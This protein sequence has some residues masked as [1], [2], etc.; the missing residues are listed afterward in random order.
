MSEDL[1]LT[2]NTIKGKVCKSTRKRVGRGN[3]SGY[4]TTCGRGCKGQKSRAGGYR[5]VGFEGGQMPLQRRL[6]KVGFSA[7]VTECAEVKL[8]ELNKLSGDVCDLKTLQEAK[9]IS[10]RAERAKIIVSGSLEKTLIVKGVKLSKGA[11][12]QIEACGGKVE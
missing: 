5:K 9:I 4:G 1:P 10:S 6:P 8:Y 3:G 2:L 7:R 11:R 12:A